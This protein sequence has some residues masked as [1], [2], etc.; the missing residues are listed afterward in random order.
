MLTELGAEVLHSDLSAS[1]QPATRSLVV[2]PNF[3]V[4]LM[5]PY[6]PALYWLTRF[7][8][9]EQIGRVSRFTFT[10]EALGRGL[11]DGTIEDVVAF[12]ERTARRACRR[13]SSSR[14]ATGR[15]RH[16]RRRAPA[17]PARSKRRGDGG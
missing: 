6:M 1:E 9:L 3:Q 5:E 13:T 14:C 7:A 2:Q 17:E 10:R 8:A 16:T 4:L 12:L 11:D 15:V